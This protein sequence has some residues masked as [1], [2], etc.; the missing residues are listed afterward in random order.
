MGCPSLDIV[1]GELLALGARN[2]LRVGTA[3]SLQQHV[4]FGDYVVARAA[5]RDEGTTARYAPL[6]FPALA[7]HGLTHTLEG[8]LAKRIGTRFHAGV[9]HCKDSLHAREFGEGPLADDNRRYMAVL[10]NCGVIASEME[11]SAL[12]VRTA[13]AAAKMSLKGPATGPL[14]RAAALLAIISDGAPFSTRDLTPVTEELIDISM[15]ALRAFKK[16]D[17]L[18][19]GQTTSPRKSNGQTP[20]VQ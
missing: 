4:H 17:L 3:G 7:D 8:A 16:A 12:Y 6:E 13:I 18:H 2:F 14:P 1:L 10:T 19:A 9:V 5:V 11:T 15:D 20:Q